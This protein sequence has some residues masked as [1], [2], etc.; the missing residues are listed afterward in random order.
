MTFQKEHPAY[1]KKAPPIYR[2]CIKCG[3]QMVVSNYQ[4][5]MGWGKYCSRKCRAQHHK[6]L[7]TGN[8]KHH[9]F[10][11]NKVGYYGIHDWFQDHFPK[12]EKCEK[13]GIEGGPNKGGRWN[14]QWALIHGKKYQRKLENFKKLCQRCHM[15]YDKTMI[16][17][18]WNKG[19][20]WSK[21]IRK[22]ISIGTKKGMMK[23]GGRHIS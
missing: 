6:E 19:K 22:K 13:C 16:K 23:N 21:E 4:L 5:K 7:F 9:N 3:N 2:K 20:K 10:K 11:G 8:G 12:P 17:G 15:E 18:G 14:I 1:N